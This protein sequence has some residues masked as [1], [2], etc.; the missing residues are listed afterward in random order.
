MFRF[1]FTLLCT[2]ALS[3]PLFAADAPVAAAPAWKNNIELGAVQTSGNTHTTTVNARL[4]SEYEND[5][6]RTTITG[7]ALNSTANK[8]TTAEK[9][10]ASLQQNW[11]F[12]VRDYL[13]ARFSF[14]SD[15]FAG[16]KRRSSE[17][18]GYGRQLIKSD[19]FAWKAEIGGGLRQSKLTDKTST[20]EAIARAAT[21]A[22]W[23]FSESSKLSEDLNTEGGARGWTSKSVT[24]LQTALNSHL[25]SKISLSLTHN[26]SVPANTRK[27]DTETAITLVV[28]F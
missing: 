4:K 5:N 18:V 2:C 3:A 9:Y 12:S 11:K 10:D 25:S 1:I 20:S 13:F 23:Q 19:S 27:L 8:A 24:A 17:T 26:S 15:R 16:F 14:E 28:N 22:A 6:W 21:N 7:S